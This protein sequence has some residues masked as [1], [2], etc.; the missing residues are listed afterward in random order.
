[1]TSIS[2]VFLHIHSTNPGFGPLNVAVQ[3]FTFWV[4]N[5]IIKYLVNFQ[6][7]KLIQ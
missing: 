3:D 7:T 6:I 4:S 2:S 1:M 5:I